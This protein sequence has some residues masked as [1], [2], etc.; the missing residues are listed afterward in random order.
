MK[1][2]SLGERIRQRRLEL[3]NMSLAK[4]SEKTGL[5]IGHLSEIENSGRKNLQSSTLKKL[6]HGLNLDVAELLDHY[7]D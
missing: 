2:L 5:S 3:N 7:G 6:A 4:L 1:K